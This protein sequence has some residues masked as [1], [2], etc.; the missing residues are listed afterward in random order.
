[1]FEILDRVVLLQ[2]E[3]LVR[4]KQVLKV[5]EAVQQVVRVYD[6]IVGSVRFQTAQNRMQIRFPKC[7]IAIEHV[8]YV[9]EECACVNVAQQ[10][11]RPLVHFQVNQ[12]AQK[13]LSYFFKGLME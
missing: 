12:T 3:L 7:E 8:D 2:N 6:D 13:D 11:P 10:V 4:R 9:G 5:Q 1:L